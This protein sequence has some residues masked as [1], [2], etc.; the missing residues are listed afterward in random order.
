[1]VLISAEHPSADVSLVQRHRVADDEKSKSA[2]AGCS[3]VVEHVMGCMKSCVQ[4]PIVAKQQ[5]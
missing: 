4:S 2:P 1:M 5:Q 3:S